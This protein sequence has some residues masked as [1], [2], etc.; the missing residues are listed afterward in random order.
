MKLATW[1]LDANSIN[2]NWDRNP[3]INRKWTDVQ[4]A[5]L[6][7]G[8]MRQDKLTNEHDRPKTTAVT[9]AATTTTTTT[10]KNKYITEKRQRKKEETKGRGKGG[11]EPQRRTTGFIPGDGIAGDATASLTSVRASLSSKWSLAMVSRGS[12]LK[13]CRKSIM[14]HAMITTTTFQ[15]VRPVGQNPATLYGRLKLTGVSI[16]PPCP[17]RMRIH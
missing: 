16:P 4:D 17:A 7:C 15:L 14:F 8:S 1:C 11:G 10:T 2:L 13:Y 12:S 5:S 3:R 9:T 6:S